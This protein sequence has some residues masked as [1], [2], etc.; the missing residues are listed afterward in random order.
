MPPIKQKPQ[1]WVLAYAKG[2]YLVDYLKH[3]DFIFNEINTATASK[4]DGFL[5]LKTM[6]PGLTLAQVFVVPLGEFLK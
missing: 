4:S 6:V 1:Q 5:L 2:D 3:P